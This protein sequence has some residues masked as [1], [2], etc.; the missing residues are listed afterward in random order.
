MEKN[1]DTVGIYCYVD[2]KLYEQFKTKYKKSTKILNLLSEI[3]EAEIKKL[4]K[5]NKNG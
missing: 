3:L 1:K 2:R 4:V 5:E